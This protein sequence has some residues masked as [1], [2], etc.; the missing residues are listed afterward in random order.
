MEIAFK[1]VQ[2]FVNYMKDHEEEKFTARE[3]AE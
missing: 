1:L 2:K 3:M